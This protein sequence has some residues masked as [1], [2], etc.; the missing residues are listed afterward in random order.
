VVTVWVKVRAV[1]MKFGSREGL[2]ADIRPPPMGHGRR[3]SLSLPNSPARRSRRRS[4]GV[5]DLTESMYIPRDSAITQLSSP[6]W[7]HER[8]ILALRDVPCQPR[9]F[10]SCACG[11]LQGTFLFERTSHENTLFDNS[12]PVR[13]IS[14]HPRDICR[15][16]PPLAELLHG[17][18]CRACTGSAMIACQVKRHAGCKR[19]NNVLRV[20]HVSSNL[21]AAP[22]K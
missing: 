13:Y 22:L 12:L 19:T 4:R 20:G 18:P 16:R 1:W 17:P 6:A 10:Y 21:P 5:V 7:V 2:L 14:R 15:A 11:W 9:K 3:P 8:S